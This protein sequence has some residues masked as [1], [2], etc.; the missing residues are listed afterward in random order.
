MVKSLI[1]TP[2]RSSNEPIMELLSPS[3]TMRVFLSLRPADV[4]DSLQ[5]FLNEAGSQEFGV[6][7]CDSVFSRADWSYFVAFILLEISL[8]AADLS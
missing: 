6:L 7:V 2:C 3:P 1:E 4:Y 5:I 8:T